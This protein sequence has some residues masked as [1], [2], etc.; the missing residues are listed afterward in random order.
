MARGRCGRGKAFPPIVAGGQSLKLPLNG[1]GSIS[2]IMVTTGGGRSILSIMV[3]TGDGANPSH[4]SL[5]ITPLMEKHEYQLDRGLGHT[6]G[7]E[8]RGGISPYCWI[9]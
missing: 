8:C 3:A 1:G 6:I 4:R 7:V 5:I 2:S 9:P